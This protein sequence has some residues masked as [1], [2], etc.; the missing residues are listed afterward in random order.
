MGRIAPAKD[1]VAVFQGNESVVRYGN[2]MGIGSE[3]S[4]GMLVAAERT[5]GV[6]HPVLSE[7]RSQPCCKGAWFGQMQQTAVE[8]K[9]AVMKGGLEPGNELAA[10]HAAKH[11]DGEEEAAR[12]VDPAA[13]VRR[14]TAC[15]Q[16]TMNMRV[17]TPTPTVP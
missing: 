3:I 8:L 14:H 13:V 17:K 10:E 16:H 2:T 9:R 4:Q 12:R 7:Q 15:G 5:L 1:D 6:D 11:L